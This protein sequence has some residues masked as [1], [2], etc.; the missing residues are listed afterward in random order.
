VPTLGYAKGNSL[1]FSLRAGARFETIIFNHCDG[2]I[3]TEN[4]AGGV[5]SG[6]GEEKMKTRTER[7]HACR[8]AWMRISRAAAGLLLAAGMLAGTSATQAAGPGGTGGTITNINGYWVHI[9]TNTAASEDF[10]ANR[11]LKN[12]EYL[13][14]GGGGSGGGGWAWITCGGGGAGGIVHTF[15]SP[16]NLAAGS[17]PIVVGAG[18]AAPGNN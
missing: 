2:C 10:V 12:V 4:R 8:Q 11:A 17:Y 16:T 3:D 15:G 9:F 18:G 6:N 13:I 5:D 1:F 14:A 7:G